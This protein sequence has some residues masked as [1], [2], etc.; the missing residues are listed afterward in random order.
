V[1]AEAVFVAVGAGA[2]AGDR[3]LDQGRERDRADVAGVADGVDALRRQVVVVGAGDVAAAAEGDEE[4]AGGELGDVGPA[5]DRVARPCGEQRNAAVVERL[6]AGQR[7]RATGGTILRV[8][9]CGGLLRAVVVKKRTAISN[10][11]SDALGFRP[12]VGLR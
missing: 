9:R 11:G 3:L 4:A 10:R 2:N 7:P 12:A 5:G 1:R 8:P 6:A